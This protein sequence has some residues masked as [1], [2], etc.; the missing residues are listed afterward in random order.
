MSSTRMCVGCE[1]RTAGV[2]QITVFWLSHHVD[3]EVNSD[4][5]DTFA[6]IMNNQVCGKVGM[7][8]SIQSLGLV[9]RPLFSHLSSV[10]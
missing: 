1:T 8:T 9:L 3:M 4:C 5:A 10:L 2:T 6:E 7:Y